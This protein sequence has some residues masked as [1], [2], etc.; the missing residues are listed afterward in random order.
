MVGKLS[1]LIKCLDNAKPVCVYLDQQTDVWSCAY[2]AVFNGM[3]LNCGM[4]PNTV[5]PDY[6]NI[7]Y[8]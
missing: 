7:M 4:E 5:D 1:T 3:L 8:K 6:Y 2:Y